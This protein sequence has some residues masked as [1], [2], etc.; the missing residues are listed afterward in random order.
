MAHLLSLV[1]FNSTGKVTHK[2]LLHSLLNTHL[3]Q[4]TSHFISFVLANVNTIHRGTRFLAHRLR[5][6]QSAIVCVASLLGIIQRPFLLDKA[7]WQISKKKFLHLVTFSKVTK[8]YI[9]CLFLSWYFQCILFSD[10]GF[11]FR[12]SPPLFFFFFFLLCIFFFFFFFFSS[13]VECVCWYWVGRSDWKKKKRKKWRRS[14]GIGGPGS[15][16]RR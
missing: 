16:G 2:I 15:P 5:W 1:C 7:R 4:A 12:P 11:Q 3:L 13:S 6:Y 10:F 14:L 8:K 9:N